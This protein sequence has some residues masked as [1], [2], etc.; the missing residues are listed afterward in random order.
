MGY[1][2]EHINLHE[3]IVPNSLAIFFLSA[4]G[5]SMLGVGIHNGDLL[6]VDRSLEVAHKRTLIAGLAASCW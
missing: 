3:F 4:S 2:E 1:I 6:V 5:D